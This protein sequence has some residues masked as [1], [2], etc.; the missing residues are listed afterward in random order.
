MRL[1]LGKGLGYSADCATE[2]PM[3]L[4]GL[5]EAAAN[6][7]DFIGIHTPI[8][9]RSPE[10]GAPER[11]R[12]TDLRLSVHS[13]TGCETARKIPCSPHECY[14]LNGQLTPCTPFCTPARMLLQISGGPLRLFGNTVTSRLTHLSLDRSAFTS[15]RP[16]P[17]TPR[18]ARVLA[19]L[20]WAVAAQ[21]TISRLTV[22]VT[23][24][25]VNDRPQVERAADPKPSAS[26]G[27]QG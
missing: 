11:K 20:G 6:L 9:V 27:R 5:M 23:L 4:A 19:L 2:R 15:F 22:A 12:P 3:Q 16:S 24:A 13:L 18:S 10:Q 26:A 14:V 21:P 7:A 25:P 1:W 17:M 8:N